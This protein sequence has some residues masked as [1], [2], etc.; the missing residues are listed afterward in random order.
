MSRNPTAGAP[1]H[2]DADH[3][4]LDSGANSL[5]Q[6]AGSAAQVVEMMG[7]ELAYNRDRIVQETR[8][9]MGTAAEAMLEAGKRLVLLKEHEQ[10]GE[11]MRIVEEQLGIPLRTAQQMMQASV[12]YLSTP[13]LASKAQTFALLGKSKMFELMTLDND[14]LVELSEGGTIAGLTLDEVDR[15]SV[16]EL[17]AALREAQADAR[18]KD[19]VLA[20]KSAT[21][22]R[23]QTKKARLQ[24]PTPDEEVAEI[25]RETSDY[26][27]QAEAII[28]GSL[29]EGIGQLSQK[30]LESGASQGEFVAGLLAQLERAIA[31]V[32]SEFGVKAAPDGNLRP[33]WDK[34][35]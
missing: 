17:K 8:F 19:D 32:R 2:D 12:K 9:Y 25:R 4:A 33:E 20:G 29:R 3:A 6:V 27:F 18:A 16:R 1:M 21:I 30:D 10:H 23:L 15:M 22:D 13:Q 24:P 5:A 31:E 34:D 14:S 26:A 28:R 11:F 35:E 7:Y